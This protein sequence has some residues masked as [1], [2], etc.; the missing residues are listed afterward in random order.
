MICFWVVVVVVVCHTIK[1]ITPAGGERGKQ[2]QQICGSPRPSI[3]ENFNKV[4]EQL[5]RYINQS[6]QMQQYRFF[7][8]SVGL[9]NHYESR[10]SNIYLYFE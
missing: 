9:V 6:G 7:S 3:G 1:V 5:V 8:K 4:D 2:N 10:V